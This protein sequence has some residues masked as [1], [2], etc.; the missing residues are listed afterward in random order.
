M[1][2]PV[3]GIPYPDAW[4]SACT[5]PGALALAASGLGVLTADGMV[6]R[7]GLSTGAT[8][9]AAAKAAILSLADPIHEVGLRLPCGI[10]VTVPVEAASGTARCWW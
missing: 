2:D 6:L 8:A 5:S 3:T 10:E 7:R 9:A 1:I 4:V